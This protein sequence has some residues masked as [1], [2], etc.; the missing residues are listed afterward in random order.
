MKIMFVAPKSISRHKYHQ[1]PFRFDYAFWN[2]FLPL[3]SLGH[4]VHFFDTS[5]FGNVEFKKDFEKFKP[6]LLFCVMTGD[7]TVC[8]DEP[9]E[10]I[11]EITNK[12]ICKTFNWFCDDSWR[13]NNF[14]SQVCKNF[15]FCSTTDEDSVLKFKEI[16]FS[17]ILYTN[18]HSNPD[19]YS[20]TFCQK[21]NLLGFIGGL[22]QD[23]SK[24][25]SCLNS[26]N[27]DV[28]SFNNSSFEDMIYL[29]SSSLAGLN[30]T[31]SPADWKRQM[32]ARIFEIPA[33]R[34]MLLTEHVDGIENLFKVEN[35]IMTF[36][37]EIDLLEK[38]KWISNNIEKAMQ[39]GMAGHQRYLNEHT[40]QIRLSNILRLLS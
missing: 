26:N 40:S 4:S 15:H 1:A 35:E 2:F 24:F 39:I 17:N 22:N 13:F 16:G 12:G 29:Y 20:N 19:V 37:N 27:F 32:K 33:T 36:E 25:I 31:K 18:W 7:K 10:S 21:R 30:F 34:T 3:T 38:V 23:R 11:I 28:V 6:E 9:W 8:P 5:E 14:S